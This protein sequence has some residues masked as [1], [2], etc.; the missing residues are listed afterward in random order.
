MSDDIVRTSFSTP[1]ASTGLLSH[2]Q[3]SKALT[4]DPGTAAAGAQPSE[5]AANPGPQIGVARVTVP[6]DPDHVYFQDRADKTQYYFLPDAFKIVRDPHPPHY[7]MMRIHVVGDSAAG[8][9]G[10]MN[11][12]AVP[13]IDAA[14]C[15]TAR[16][17]FEALAEDGA[18]IKWS[19]LPLPKDRPRFGL[20]LPGGD[21]KGGPFVERPGVAVSLVTG[22]HDVYTAAMNQFQQLFDALFDPAADFFQGKVSVRPDDEGEIDIPFTARLTDFVGELFEQTRSIDPDTGDLTLT[23]SNAIEGTIHVEDLPVKV[24]RGDDEIPCMVVTDPLLPIDLAPAADGKPADTLA[25]SLKPGDGPADNDL[26][27]TCDLGSTQVLS[28]GKALLQAIL[29]PSVPSNITRSVTIKVPLGT[30]GSAATPADKQVTAVQVV[31]EGGH[32]VTL[33]PPDAATPGQHFATA[34]VQL[35]TPTLDFLLHKTNVGVN[36]YRYYVNLIYASGASSVAQKGQSWRTDS[37]DTLFI[38]GSA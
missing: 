15:G 14:R 2:Q 31:F 20:N 21:G 12:T 9:N 35:T 25:I 11:Y 28:E 10:V 38:V 30:F 33:Y 26:L 7:P 32:D 36:Q 23:L 19:P 24:R 22:F 4:G 29:D 5:N 3:L 18:L 1:G 13:V 37:L 8:L 16:A 34:T 17:H 27:V 6:G